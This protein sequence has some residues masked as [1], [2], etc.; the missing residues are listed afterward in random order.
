MLKNSIIQ[1]GFMGV[2]KSTVGLIVAEKLGTNYYDTDGW[3]ET[4]SGINVPDLVRTDMAA[5]RGLEAAT[6]IEI[7]G[8]EPGVISTGGGIVST[9]VGRSALIASGVPVIWMKTS[10]DV[11]A[12]RVLE[13]NIGRERPLFDDL[14]K[15]RGRYDERQGWYEETATHIVDASR[16]PE[17]VAGDIVAIARIE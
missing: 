15:A 9:E 12:K 2:G 7:L 6:L 13:D 14:E 16:T 5:F 17:L 1:T 8:L 4:E 10:F 3:M 11:A